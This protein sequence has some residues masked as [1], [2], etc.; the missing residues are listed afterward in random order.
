MKKTLFLLVFIPLVSFSQSDLTFEDIKKIDS[1][2]TFIKTV[3]ENGYSRDNIK[4]QDDGN[5]VT[6]YKGL[7]NRVGEIAIFI[8]SGDKWAFEFDFYTF[9]STDGD[10]GR[11]IKNSF[12][13]S[14]NPDNIIEA[15]INE[16][17]F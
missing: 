9:P 11:I 16:C 14:A 4:V 6:T 2:A 15:I 12:E 10:T 13:F 8:E 7:K 1:K 3:I 17:N 5:V